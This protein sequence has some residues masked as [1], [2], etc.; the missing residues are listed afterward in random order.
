[1]NGDEMEEDSEGEEKEGAPSEMNESAEPLATAPMPP[2]PMAPP[3]MAPMFMNARPIGQGTA[4]NFLF[5]D[6][7][8]ALARIR[9]PQAVEQPYDE[10]MGDEREL[11]E[12]K[13]KGM[14]F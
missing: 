7:G 12:D 5:R 2:A 10:D 1:M 14:M 6:M 9:I 13:G 11:E 3:P 4:A 8:E